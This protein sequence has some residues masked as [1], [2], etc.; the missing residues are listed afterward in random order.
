METAAPAPGEI[1]LQAH[2]GW[3]REEV[4]IHLFLKS[5]ILKSKAER[6]HLLRGV[7]VF[8]PCLLPSWREFRAILVPLPP[9]LLPLNTI[10]KLMKKKK[11]YFKCC[12]SCPTLR[13]QRAVANARIQRSLHLSGNPQTALSG[14][15]HWNMPFSGLGLIFG[16]KGQLAPRPRC[17]GTPAPATITDY[18]L[19]QPFLLRPTKEAILTSW[20]LGKFKETTLL[21]KKKRR[22]L[23]LGSFLCQGCGWEH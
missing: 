22:G 14:C 18:Q 13:S 5:L 12:P 16:S 9:P 19:L 15:A 4:A 23:V 2:G 7:K 1:P 20:G 21:K 3:G 8:Y 17:P 10:L 11:R 6:T